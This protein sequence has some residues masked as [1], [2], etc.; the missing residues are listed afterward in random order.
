M[1]NTTNRQP[2]IVV[3]DVH[4]DRLRKLA[5]AALE[6]MPEVADVLLE[7]LDRA[8]IVPAGRF[9]AD[10]V[11]MLGW[12]EYRDRRT[13]RTRT[14]QLVYPE[15]ADIAAGR[16]SIM[17]PVGAALLGLSAGQ[18]MAWSARDGSGWDLVVTKVLAAPPAVA[19]D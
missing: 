14:V 10:A 4:A 15:D 1:T 12:A 8:R 9:P 2:P 19:V 5:T 7:E 18:A 13:G 11:N 17:T 6:R 3:E 16:V